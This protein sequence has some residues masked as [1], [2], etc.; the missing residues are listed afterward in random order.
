MSR[1]DASFN[2]SS[3]PAPPFGT[4][5]SPVPHIEP[6]FLQCSIFLYPTEEDAPSGANW[7]GSGFLAGI[8]SYTNPSYRHL[9]AV[10]NDHVIHTNPTIRLIKEGG[11]TEIVKRRDQDW[12]PHPGGDDIAV[13]QLGAVPEGEYVFLEREELLTERMLSEPFPLVSPGDDCFMVGRYIDRQQRQFDRPVIRFG[14]LAMLVE[15]VRQQRRSFEQESFLVEMRSLAGFS[16]S[17]VFVYYEAI[18]P[19]VPL[20][21]WWEANPYAWWEGT[22]EHWPPGSLPGNR[23]P[24]GIIERLWLLGIDW[25]HLPM[26]AD[27]IDEDGARMGKMA[28]NSG[29]AGVVPAWKLTELLDSARF[30]AERKHAD[31]HLAEEDSEQLRD[32]L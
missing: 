27:V 23:S 3:C 25:G 32:P 30:V 31:R 28:V 5:K 26:W 16:G 4:W 12:T 17:P 1:P 2:E 22:P 6:E 14:N 20:P 21:D 10:S 18:G 8:R 29:M 24:S 9:Y 15:S 13:C 7:G 11:S 19:R